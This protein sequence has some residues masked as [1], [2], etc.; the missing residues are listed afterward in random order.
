MLG[1]EIRIEKPRD[2]DTMPVYL[3]AGSEH[4]LRGKLDGDAPE[5]GLPRR[6]R[7]AGARPVNCLL[8]NV[9]TRRCP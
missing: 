7:S 2:P 6:D 3:Q 9:K 5:P 1:T 4:R 8:G